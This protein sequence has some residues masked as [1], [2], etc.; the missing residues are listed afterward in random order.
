MRLRFAD[1]DGFTRQQTHFISIQNRD[2]FTSGNHP[3]FFALLMLLITQ[4]MARMNI[5]AFHFV[6]GSFFQNL[7]EAPWRDP[8]FFH[9]TL[10]S[11][12]QEVERDVCASIDSG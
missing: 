11:L 8:S 2:R 1:M 6:I 10:I 9:G 3:C 7:P 12:L 4:T 5:N